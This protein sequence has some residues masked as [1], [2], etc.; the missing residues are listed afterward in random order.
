MS[1]T[2]YF[3]GIKNFQSENVC[4]IDLHLQLKTIMPK[5]NTFIADPFLFKYK[6]EYYAF[7]ELWDYHKGKIAYSK[8]DQHYNLTD[9]KICLEM[10]YHLSFPCIFTYQ[11][12]IYM[13]PETT[14]VRCIQ[15]FECE[16]FPS[17]WKLKKKL[18]N[19]IYA[20][21]VSFFEYNNHV[22]LITNDTDF[23][24]IFVANN[25]FDEFKKHP[26][27][28]QKTITNARNA[29]NIF[30]KNNIL[31]RPG[32]ICQPKYGYGIALYK[33]NKLSYTEYEEEI[34][35]KYMPDWFPELT[36]CHTF[37]ICDNL[38]II[39]G[40]LK[41]K[42]PNMKPV[43]SVNGK[44]YKSTD[45]DEFVNN[46]IS[47]LLT[48]TVLTKNIITCTNERTYLITSYF[49]NITGTCLFVGVGKYTQ[50]YEFINKDLKY[51]TIDINEYRAKY[52][53][54]Q[55][56]YIKDFN[57]FVYNT[58]I[59]HINLFGVLGHSPISQSGIEYTLDNDLKICL[60]KCSQL[61]NINGTILLG[62]SY[63][64][65]K[66]F[67]KEY[68]IKLFN[69]IIDYFKITNYSII[70]GSC[71]IILWFKVNNYFLENTNN[72]IIELK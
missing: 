34:I 25:L 50:S 35:N 28:T 59:N 48:S 31:Y 16:E 11:E 38:L 29:G 57:E 67:N 46:Y 42:S 4:N 40:R 20:P 65:I 18:I 21:D 44:V 58:K 52:G 49:P 23:L 9:V 22:Y 8:L 36:G 2:K 32:Q 51:I 6:E 19:N 14:S 15:L 61:I 47:N 39:D 70:I 24:K 64:S 7:F 26:I 66:E 12:K 53:S 33:I 72:E 43:N 71:N 27:N 30:I 41:I 62:P 60:S 55:E 56:H 68:W 5:K 13:I 1:V 45:D 69:I 17:K 3:L 10:P 37:N 63:I 54:T